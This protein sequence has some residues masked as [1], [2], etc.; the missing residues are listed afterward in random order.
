MYRW[1]IAISL[2][3]SLVLGLVFIVGCESDAQTGALVGA[4][5]G[6][7]AGQAIGRNTTGT[8]I[9]T[10]VGAGAGYVIGNEGDKKKTQSQQ[11]NSSNSQ[12]GGD[13][14]TVNIHNANG[15]ISPVTLKRN[16]A[17]YAGPKG[18]LYDHLPTESELRQAGY[19]L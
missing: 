15:S 7:L 5:A 10:A 11:S 9:G 12:Y 1:S 17:R 16:G 2:V 6:A 3:V 19:G 4:G 14:I 8:L 18:E 13:T